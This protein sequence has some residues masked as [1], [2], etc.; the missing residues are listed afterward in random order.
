VGTDA[1][2][3]QAGYAWFQ[4]VLATIPAA[5]V[6]ITHFSSV[7]DNG[8][9]CLNGTLLATNCSWTVP[10]DVDLSGA[11]NVSGPNVLTVLIQNTENIGGIDSAVTFGA[12]QTKTTLANWLQQGGPGDPNATT[13]WQTLPGPGSFHG[14]QFFKSTF[15]APPMGTAGADPMW[16]VTTT[17]LSHG[18]VWVNGHNLGRYPEK[19]AAP[20]IYVPECWLNPGS[21]ANTLVIYDEGGNLPAQVRVQAEAAAS[22]DMVTFQSALTVATSPP[23]PVDESPLGT[24]LAKSIT[25]RNQKSGVSLLPVKG[26]WNSDHSVF[27][28][29]FPEASVP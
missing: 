18:S 29:A 7:D 10:F 27:Q 26:T 3:R 20:G 9:V 28:P 22:R 8:W 23:P 11:W 24:A 4:T 19:V 16:R 25:A 21:N 6:E 12:W 14:P 2:G 17:G 1:F 5:R 13:G 15:T